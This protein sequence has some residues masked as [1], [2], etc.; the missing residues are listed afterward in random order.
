VSAS[1]PAAPSGTAG[2]RLTRL[3]QLVPWLL[4]RPGISQRETAEHFDVTEEQLLADLDLLICSGPGQFHG[5]LLDIWYDDEGGITV[6]DPLSLTRPLRLTSE[7]ASALL[8]GLRLLAQVPG[9]QDS[10]TVARVT[11]TLEAAAGAS[12]GAVAALDV[13]VERTLDPDVVAAMERA[14][15]EGRVV[16][17]RYAGATR[18]QETERDVVPAALLS[19]DGRP[20][21]SGWCRR[22]EAMRTFRLDRVLAADVLQERASVPADAAGP[23]LG[24]GALRPDGPTLTLDLAPGARWVADEYPVDSVVSLPGGGARVALPVSDPR[25]VVRLLLRLGGSATVVAPA[26]IASAVAQE[27][28][29]ALAA[30]EPGDSEAL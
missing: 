16:R 29:K 4:A 22:A 6:Q 1:T 15:A 20:Y 3:L 25:W 17:L 21:L 10:Q 26:E 14:V 8:V 18:D 2:A 12:A 13:S 9:G 11:A 5:E 23:D 27:A 28:L 7:E 24:T 19:L 30:Y